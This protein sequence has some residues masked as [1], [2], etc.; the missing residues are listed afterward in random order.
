MDRIN[1][2]NTVDIG[3]GKRGFRAQ[4]KAAGIA[5]T[6]LTAAWFTSVQ[7]EIMAVIEG[8]G[9]AADA[10]TL[11]Q[12][13]DAI[14]HMISVGA[15]SIDLS[16][17]V[18]TTALTAA[19]SG[20][21]SADTIRGSSAGGA[22]ASFSFS[23]LGLVSGV[24]AAADKSISFNGASVGAG[25]MDAGAMPTSGD[26]SV[27]AI[28][29]PT[30]GVWAALGCTYA[31]S[32]GET[33]TGSAMPSGYTVSRLISVHRTTSGSQFTPFVQVGRRINI[34]R[35]LINAGLNSST[36]TSVGTVPTPA[37]AATARL[38]TQQTTTSSPSNIWFAPTSPG[39]TSTLTHP[40]VVTSWSSTAQN[41][42]TTVDVAIVAV[43]TLY[44]YTSQGQ[45]WS[46][47][48]TG[49]TF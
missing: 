45:T 5:G 29:N 46:A 24:L 30:T 35:I 34:G 25:G 16:G 22:T 31:T 40:G 11:H 33:Y 26:L 15:P 4:N 36:W 8:A 43:G 27:Y 10:A 13:R 12:L 1:G 17:Y 38:E 39:A 44:H 3:S 37:L 41:D 2:A 14:A 7:E 42:T 20:F 32:H 6:E 48:L 18:T 9:I 47:W 23:A 19:V 21:V 28:Y 49:Y